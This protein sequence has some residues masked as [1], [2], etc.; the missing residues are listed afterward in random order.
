MILFSYLF[1][2]IVAHQYKPKR[3]ALFT[4]DI[5]LILQ[6]LLTCK[7]IKRIKFEKNRNQ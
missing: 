1:E 5:Y 6:A 2:L 3:Q 7:K 4:A